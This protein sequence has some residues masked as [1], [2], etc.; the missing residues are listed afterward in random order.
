[1]LHLKLNLDKSGLVAETDHGLSID[2]TP[3]EQG[4]NQLLRMLRTQSEPKT[5]TKRPGVTGDGMRLVLAE[6]ERLPGEGNGKVYVGP[7]SP[8]AAGKATNAPPTNPAVKRFTKRGKP[9]DTDLPP[10]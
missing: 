3:G 4:Y 5:I 9:I 7:R 2:I 1:M 6:W 10:L 8:G